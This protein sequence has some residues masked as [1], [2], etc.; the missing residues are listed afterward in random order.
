MTKDE[1]EE[2]YAQ[3]SGVTVG[4]LYLHGRYGIPCDCGDPMCEGWQMTHTFDIETGKSLPV[5]LAST[6]P[7][8]DSSGKCNG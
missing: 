7:T 5:A 2:A 3:R 8:P 1:F 4:F 6:L